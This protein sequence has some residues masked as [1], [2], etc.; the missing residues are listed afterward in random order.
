MNGFNPA[1]D[2]NHVHDLT[3]YNFDGDEDENGYHDAI[4]DRSDEGNT[5]FSRANETGLSA[6]RSTSSISDREK[7][8]PIFMSP[9]TDD[10]YRERPGHGYAAKM[11][12]SQF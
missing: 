1:L 8:P 7:S 11:R 12:N 5:T 4:E 3:A 2:R 9:V 6:L 10:S